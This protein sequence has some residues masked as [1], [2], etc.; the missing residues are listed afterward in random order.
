MAWCL[1]LSPV[2]PVSPPLYTVRQLALELVRRLGLSCFVS[3][4]C[5]A[6]SIRSQLDSISLA[7]GLASLPHIRSSHW[8]VYLE[9][10]KTVF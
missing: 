3:K 8:V 6:R 1:L 4:V 7:M 10:Q 5:A 2:L 9:T